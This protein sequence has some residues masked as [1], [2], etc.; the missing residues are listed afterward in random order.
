ME[1]ILES[2]LPVG[3]SS[4]SL[5]RRRKLEEDSYSEE[6]CNVKSSENSDVLNGRCGDGYHCNKD[7]KGKC[8]KCKNNRC[9]NCDYLEINA[10]NAF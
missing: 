7:E 3:L 4:F 8:E 10:Q 6:E 9:K 1:I 2:D 5:M